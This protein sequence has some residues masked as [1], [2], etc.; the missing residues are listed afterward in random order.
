M[1]LLSLVSFPKEPEPLDIGAVDVAADTDGDEFAN[2]G[3]VAFWAD[4]Q[5]A[6]STDIT[7]VA[8]KKCDFG[9]MHDAVETVPAG[10]KGLIAHRLDPA[11]FND[12]NG[13]VQV[14]YSSVATL[15]VAAVVLEE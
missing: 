14:T 12:A 1:S 10:F 9:F 15:F 13:R 8:Q 4:N 7:F 5:D 11:R 2:V 6:S 3:H